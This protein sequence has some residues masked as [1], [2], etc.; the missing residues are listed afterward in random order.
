[1]VDITLPVQN[2]GMGWILKGKTLGDAKKP[3]MRSNSKLYLGMPF[4]KPY[5][6]S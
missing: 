5:M 6:S 4:E 1:M 3:S 2:D